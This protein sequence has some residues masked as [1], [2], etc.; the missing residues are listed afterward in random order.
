[1]DIYPI[2]GWRMYREGYIHHTVKV[3]LYQA[4]V[5]AYNIIAL[6]DTASPFR[7]VIIHPDHKAHKAL[8]DSLMDIVLDD[9][10]DA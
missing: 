5:C 1:M 6:M 4:T 3:D 10:Y 9:P 7:K 2:E 8:I